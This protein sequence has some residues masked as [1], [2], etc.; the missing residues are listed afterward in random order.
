MLS[1]FIYT[2]IYLIRIFNQ[3]KIDFITSILYSKK[4]FF[5]RYEF[6]K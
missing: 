3:L 6:Y 5:V 1:M 2:L 4:I